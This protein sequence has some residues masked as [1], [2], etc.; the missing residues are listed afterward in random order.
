MCRL[1]PVID[2]TTRTLYTANVGDD[3]ISIVDLAAC[4][5]RNTAGCD[6]ASTQ[7]SLINPNVIA[8][9]AR[10][11]SLYMIQEVGDRLVVLDSR[12]CRAGDVSGCEATHRT[13]K[14]GDMPWEIRLDPTTDTLFLVDHANGD[15]R[16]A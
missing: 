12:H 4:T 3:T 15:L 14:T 8:I 10:T 11:H 9:D 16:P 5:A 6:D 1:F 7:A 13:L 2:Q